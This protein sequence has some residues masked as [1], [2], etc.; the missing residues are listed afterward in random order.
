MLFKLQLKDPTLPTLDFLK[1][2]KLNQ[3]ECIIS[4][5]RSRKLIYASTVTA[6]VLLLLRTRSRIFRSERE[7]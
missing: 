1:L 2:D 4:R 6:K 3:L 7:E 5:C